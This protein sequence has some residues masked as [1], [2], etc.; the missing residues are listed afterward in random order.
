M[1]AL[2]ET[3]RHRNH[4]V[5]FCA[6]DNFGDRIRAHGF[7]FHRAGPDFGYFFDGTQNE[8]KTL[9]KVFQRVPEQFSSL[10]EAC[11]NADAVVG[12]MLQLAA[13]SVAETLRIPYF[14]SVFSP[15]YLRSTELPPLSLPVR[16]IPAWMHRSLWW[17][18]DALIPVLGRHFIRERQ[19]LGLPAPSSIYE[20][21]AHSGTLL[22][23]VEPELLPI[24]GDAGRHHLTGI[25]RLPDRRELTPELTAF[26]EAGPPPVYAG[27]GSMK[28]RNPRLVL[29]LLTGAARKAGQRLL[30]S[31]GW[32][33]LGGVEPPEGCLVVRDVPHAVLFP[34]L[35][36]VV[37]HGGAGTLASAAIAGV[38]QIIVPHL[39]DQH[40]H[41]LRVSELGLGPPPLPFRSCTAN[42]LAQAM[43]HVLSNGA[44]QKRA[45][46]FGESLNPFGGVVFAS[47]IIE[48]TVAG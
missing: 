33:E 47:E 42:R 28:H 27:F 39:G 45:K 32:S 26:L 38:P 12:A 18:Q 14:Y 23:A 19:K 22:L 34:R 1:L 24:P 15:A 3:L 7:P 20:Y 17:L 48:K 29:N 43:T 30:I 25:W 46:A 21:L 5:V 37:H 4:Q 40:Y 13:P 41:G 44:F 36:A 35:A 9:R 16:S 6:P 31:T 10:L 11:A 8:F 2:G